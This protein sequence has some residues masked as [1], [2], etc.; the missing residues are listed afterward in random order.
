M[1]A[2]RKS[3]AQ[4]EHEGLSVEVVLLDFEKA[5]DQIDRHQHPVGHLSGLFVGTASYLIGEKLVDYEAPA[6]IWIPANVDHQITAKVAGTRTACIFD[7]RA[8]HGLS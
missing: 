3:Y 5:G 8:I 6:L 4:T 2:P 7:A 1:A